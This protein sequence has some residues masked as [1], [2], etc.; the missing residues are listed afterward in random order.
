MREDLEDAYAAVDWAV[1]Y[2]PILGKIIDD[3]RS[4]PAFWLVEEPHPEIGQK[5]FKLEVNRPL[6]LTVN[7]AAGI[8]INS[9]RTSLDL[10]GA[11]LAQ[12]NGKI[13]TSE[14]HFPVYASGQ[15]FCD[16]LNA[17]KRKKWMRES[18]CAVIESLKPYAGGNDLLYALHQ[19]DITRKHERLVRAHLALSGASVS[20]EA[21][22]QGFRCPN[23]WPG[24]KDGAVI[25]WTTINAT[26]SDFQFT[27]DVAFSEAGA[28]EGKPIVTSLREFAGLAESII[29]LFEHT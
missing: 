10:L 13:P 1:T 16:P 28:V 26:K 15:D 18:E 7:A 9:I 6:P 23:I 11:S 29:Q 8:V 19:L 3:W 2:L 14:H 24:F 4:A 21:W 5:L 17:Q 12:R 27:G 22:A 25:A 20:P